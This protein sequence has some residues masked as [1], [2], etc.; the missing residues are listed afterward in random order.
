MHEATVSS[1]W[2]LCLK[3]HLTHHFFTSKNC[4]ILFVVLPID[5]KCGV[6][7]KHPLSI[8]FSIS[9]LPPEVTFHQFYFFVQGPLMRK[10]SYRFLK[11][12]ILIESSDKMCRVYSVLLFFG[13]YIV[14]ILKNV[15]NVLQFLLI[16]AHN[17]IQS[18]WL[19]RCYKPSSDKV[20]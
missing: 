8:R 19:S 10:V 18:N 6:I 7:E 3:T 20:K 1:F 15:K 4:M 11:D 5:G 14:S 16:S 2:K 12:G 17:Q 13:S 9:A